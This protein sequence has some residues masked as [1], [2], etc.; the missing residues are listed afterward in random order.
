MTPH[1]FKEKWGKKYQVML[2]NSAPNG[3]KYERG[4]KLSW[5]SYGPEYGM[6]RAR[7]TRENGKRLKTLI[8][9]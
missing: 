4:L 9:T 6:L 3:R 1:D 5:E 7:N 8:K 2:T